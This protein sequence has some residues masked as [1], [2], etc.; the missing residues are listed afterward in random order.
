MISEKTLSQVPSISKCEIHSP[1]REHWAYDIMSKVI[2][3]CPVTGSDE[4]I[5]TYLD[6]EEL[7]TT[8]RKTMEGRYARV[9]KPRKEVK[10]ALLPMVRCPNFKHP[11]IANLPESLK[12][13]LWKEEKVWCLKINKTCPLE[14]LILEKCRLIC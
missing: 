1:E 12:A 8:Q 5:I 13:Q 11:M 14:Q 2:R 3:N 7:F 9:L 6:P 10:N 4:I